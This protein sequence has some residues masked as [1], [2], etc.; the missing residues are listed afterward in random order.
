MIE[1][2]NAKERRRIQSRLNELGIVEVPLPPP[3]VR[4]DVY[5]GTIP[6]KSF[7]DEEELIGERV[8]CSWVN[9][10][11]KGII[12][13]QSGILKKIDFVNGKKYYYVD[14]DRKDYAGKI[15]KDEEFIMD[16]PAEHVR[17]EAT[18]DIVYPS[19]RDSSGHITE[20]ESGLEQDKRLLAEQKEE[21]KGGKKRKTYKKSRRT[22]RTRRTRR[23]RRTRR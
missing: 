6:K 17:I 13:L 10:E 2:D 18:E 16:F 15:V 21:S 20:N 14:L 7:G 1:Y 22:R 3:L 4:S 23:K 9:P 19:T 8:L 5:R 12:N 11:E